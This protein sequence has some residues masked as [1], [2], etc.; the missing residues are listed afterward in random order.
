MILGTPSIGCIVN[1]MKEAEVDALAMLW[2]N[3][4]VAHLLVHRMMMEV[5]DGLK[6]E[7]GPN[8]ND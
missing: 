3:A 4:R 1:M 2:V 7:L 8:S 5:G 6:K